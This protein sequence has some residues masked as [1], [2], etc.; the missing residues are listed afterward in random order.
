MS[1]SPFGTL[2]PGTSC[3]FC[4]SG[5]AGDGGGCVG[6]WVTL[7]SSF[8]RRRRCRVRFLWGP[9]ALC[10]HQ[11][12][13]NLSI[14]FRSYSALC[15]CTCWL[16]IMVSKTVDVAQTMTFLAGDVME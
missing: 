11:S 5:P 12:S 14:L 8:H 7:Q 15:T 16:P 13:Y 10:A 1:A 4:L 3:F 2:S 9:L 6:V